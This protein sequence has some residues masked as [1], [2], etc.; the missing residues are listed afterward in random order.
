MDATLQDLR[1][2]RQ[3]LRLRTGVRV[4]LKKPHYPPEKTFERSSHNTY[5]TNTHEFSLRVHLLRTRDTFL[6]SGTI[7][8]EIVF[9]FWRKFIRKRRGV[10][11]SGLPVRGGSRACFK[12]REEK[13]G[14]VEMTWQ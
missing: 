9:Q 12:G 6:A 8:K 14:E 13:L 10:Y 2:W 1:W 5:A 11:D 4:Q 3:S 7:S